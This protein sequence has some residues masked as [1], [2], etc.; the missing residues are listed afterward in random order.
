MLLNDSDLRN[1]PPRGRHVCLS[2]TFQSCKLIEN[3]W[4][5]NL[6]ERTDGQLKLE[7]TDFAELGLD[8]PKALSLVDEGTLEMAA[9]F[10]L[11]VARDLP[12]ILVNLN[13][14]RKA[15]VPRQIKDSLRK[16][17]RKQF[18]LP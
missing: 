18:G 6:S 10:G 7:V 5:P 14:G 1:M 9:I 3:Y 16:L 11:F 13:T 2:R 15:P 8:G 17:I 12:E 4:A